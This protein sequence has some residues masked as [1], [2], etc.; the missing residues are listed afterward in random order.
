MQGDLRGKR[1]VADLSETGAMTTMTMMMTM[2]KR[3]AAGMY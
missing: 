1:L 3:R 2:I